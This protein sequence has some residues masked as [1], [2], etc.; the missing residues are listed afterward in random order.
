MNLFVLLA[1]AT[2]AFRPTD[3]LRNPFWPTD[4]EYTEKDLQPIT[5]VPMVD[6]NARPTESE[7]KAGVTGAAVAALARNTRVVSPRNWSEA[8]KKLH[9]RGKTSVVDV[10]TGVKRTAFFINGNTYGVGD[11]ISVNHEGRRFTW[12]IRQRADTKTLR[13]EQV[14][15]VDLPEDKQKKQEGKKK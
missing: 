7:D 9:F 1:A 12:R 4:F 8:A 5:T 3:P 14:R 2:A 13:L 11:L 10:M 15:V 6:I